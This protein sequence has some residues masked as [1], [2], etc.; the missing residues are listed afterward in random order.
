MSTRWRIVPLLLAGLV[1]VGCLCMA[2]APNGLP[3]GKPAP[4]IQG[5]DSE[6][7][8]FTLHDYRGKVVLLSFWKLG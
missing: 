3:T 6:G 8:R 7:Q 1:L 5:T 4:E 2:T